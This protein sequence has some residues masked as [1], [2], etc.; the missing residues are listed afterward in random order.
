MR[1]DERVAHRLRFARRM[2]RISLATLVAT[3]GL[4]AG[5]AHADTV[6]LDARFHQPIVTPIFHAKDDEKV[7]VTKLAKNCDPQCR[8]ALSQTQISKARLLQ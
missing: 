2:S 8:A 4:L 1:A 3:A 6:R 5:H 7:Y